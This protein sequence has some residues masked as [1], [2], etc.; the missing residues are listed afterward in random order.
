MSQGW[1]K[2]RRRCGAAG[3]RTG[4]SGASE[5]NPDALP[6][7]AYAENRLGRAGTD[8]ETDSEISAIEAW[9]RD[10]SEAVADIVAARRRRRRK[11][12]ACRGLVARRANGFDRAPPT[13]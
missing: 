11:Q 6:L 2:R 13:T 5:P 8:P 10:H 7:A 12:H 1:K 3:R 4:S 9:L